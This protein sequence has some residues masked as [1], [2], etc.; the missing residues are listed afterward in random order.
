M[1]APEYEIAGRVNPE[2]KDHIS[3]DDGTILVKDEE[4]DVYLVAQPVGGES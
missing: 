1:G 4:E 2:V 3:S